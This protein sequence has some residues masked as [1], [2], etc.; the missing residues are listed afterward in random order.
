LSTKSEFIYPVKNCKCTP[1]KAETKQ[2][3][4]Q[5][6]KTSLNSWYRHKRQKTPL[7]VV[8][9]DGDFSARKERE[10]AEYTLDLMEGSSRK[11]EK[12]QT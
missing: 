2:P 8:A 9:K 6:T 1:K 5:N 11:E 7:K 12:R 4:H 10:P 3:K